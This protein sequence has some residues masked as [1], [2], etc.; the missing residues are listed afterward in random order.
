M[1]YCYNCFGRFVRPRRRFEAYPDY[2]GEWHEHCP[3]CGAPEF[4]EREVELYD[5]Q[6]DE[7]TGQYRPQL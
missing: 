7:S 1:Y 4:F 6:R 5:D 3:L 2:G